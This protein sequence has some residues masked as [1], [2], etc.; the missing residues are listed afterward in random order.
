MPLTRRSFLAGASSLALV[1][2]VGDEMARALQR[3]RP[4]PV[5]LPGFPF[6]LGVAS[7]D[8]HQNG[9]VL[10]TRLAPDP[11]AG[12][13]MPPTDVA[14]QWEV[15]RDEHMRQVIRRGTAVARPEYAHAVHVDVHGLGPD[16]WYWYRFR[17]GDWVSRL[18]R[19]RTMPPPSR[20]PS[21]LAFAFASCQNYPAGYYTAYRHMADDDLDLVVHLGDYIYEGGPGSGPRRHD[22]PEVTTLDAYRNRY[23]LYKTDPDLQAAHAA[24][25]WAVTWDDHEVDN[26]YAG[27]VPEDGGPSE[28]FL[29]RRAAAY[30]AYWEHLPM[31]V[32]PPTGPDMRIHRRIELGGLAT[33]HLLDQRQY[34][35]PIAC[36]E[37]ISSAGPVCDAMDDPNHVLLGA[38]QQRWLADGLAATRSRWQV[39]ATGTVMSELDLLKPSEPKFVNLDQ[40]DGYPNARRQLLE[41]VAASGSDT[42]VISGDIHA[43]GVGSLRLDYDDPD[44]PDIATEFVGTSI[45]STAN[46]A[47]GTL[48]DQ[49][50]ESHP[51]IQWADAAHRGYVRCT[52]S[53]D[54]YR[55]EYQHL[56]TALEPDSAIRT[57]TSWRVEPGRPGA[58]QTG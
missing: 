24:F 45:S 36:P 48:V 13:G 43:S 51:H 20:R 32:P 12:G 53:H 56:D 1:G 49:V 3:R 9:V 47:F 4:D 31:R 19:T 17:V 29:Q 25:P 38:E 55:A 27:D 7:G 41:A 42:V 11:L 16:R 5:V 52:L 22:G 34:R 30:R 8:P 57:A 18:G 58:I 14:V 26:N 6:T 39:L 28:P 2:P 50:V 37:V 23:A 35:S 40:W 10:W 44:A 54:E 21:T 33:V 15:A 46:S